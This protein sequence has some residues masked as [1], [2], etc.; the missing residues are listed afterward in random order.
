M[1]VICDPPL[2]EENLLKLDEYIQQRDSEFTLAALSYTSYLEAYAALPDGP[3]AD[4]R[5]K[6]RVI[7][8]TLREISEEI[9]FTRRNPRWI[10]HTES[11]CPHLG[12]NVIRHWEHAVPVSYLHDSMLEKCENVNMLDIKRFCAW[13]MTLVCVE[14]AENQQ[15]DAAGLRRKMPEGWNVFGHQLARYDAI[16]LPIQLDGKCPI[17]WPGDRFGPPTRNDRL[18]ENINLDH[19]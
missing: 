9:D 3:P 12:D 16:G 13:H 19:Y 14:H 8:A 6:L 4:E 1:C 11:A 5:S 10:Y 17:C 7:K 15:L 18:L 2:S